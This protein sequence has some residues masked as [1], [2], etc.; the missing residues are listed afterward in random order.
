MPG[1]LHIGIDISGRENLA[2]FINENGDQIRSTLTFSNDQ[3]G[4]EL[5]LVE[6][7]TCVD[8]HNP[9]LV[10][11]GMEATGFYWWHLQEALSDVHL[12]GTDIKIF[13]INPKLIKNFKKAYPSLPKTDAVDAWVIAER[14]RFGRLTPL[15]KGSLIYAPLARL[16]RLRCTMKQNIQKEKNRAINLT[17]LKFSNFRQAT[18]NKHFNKSSCELLEEFTPDEI[19]DKPLEELVDFILGCG[20]NRIANPEEFTAEIQKAARNSYRLNPKMDD[21]VSIALAMTIENI[22]FMEKQCKKLDQSIQRELKAIPQ[23]LTTIPG[24]ASTLAAGIIAEIG[25]VF[26]ITS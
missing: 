23:T 2:C 1:A 26:L 16:T 14:L 18:G 24:I 4:L 5:F 11:I 22:R 13:T 3:T 21:T 20:N 6:L 19:A 25:F 17:F 12:Q 10:N 8:K 15:H 7:T 9:E